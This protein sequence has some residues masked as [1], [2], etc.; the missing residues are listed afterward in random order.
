MVCNPAPPKVTHVPDYFA[1][2]SCPLCRKVQVVSHYDLQRYGRAVDGSA[3]WLCPICKNSKNG[4]P[5][6]S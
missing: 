5:D 4:S 3:E 6:Q 1:L 2:A